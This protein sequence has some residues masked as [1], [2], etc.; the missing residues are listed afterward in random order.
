MISMLLWS[1]LSFVAGCSVG[2]VLLVKVFFP[3]IDHYL[4]R[5]YGQPKQL[6]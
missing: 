5:K 6:T 2:G 4:D 3:L 1:L